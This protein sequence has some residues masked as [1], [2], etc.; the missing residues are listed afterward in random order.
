MTLTHR[1]HGHDVQTLEIRLEPGQT[2]VAEVGAM[3]YMDDGIQM[4]SRLGNSQKDGLAQSILKAG[5]RLLGGEGLFVTHFRNT[6]NRT[7]FAAFAAPHPGSIIA[8]EPAAIAGGLI[9]Q[10][11][12][13]L[14]GSEGTQVSLA[15]QKK[16]MAG[17]F[18]GEGF[19]LQR[20]QSTGSLFLHASGS[21]LSRELAAG[22][23]LWVDTGCFVA[24]QASVQY[25]IQMVKGLKSM[26]F[27]G[28]GMFLLKLTGPG[29]VWL[30]SAPFEHTLALIRQE[31]H[32]L[33]KSYRK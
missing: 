26:L 10:R 33:L 23:T 17:L 22:Q 4:E 1:I 15:F 6:S 32:Q 24:M 3:L 8:P 19:F 28:E 11:G 12:A 30:Q 29:Q 27:A 5:K 9:A 16:M 18:G 13:F 7:C 2:A 31:V 20:L 14:C 21:V 25:D